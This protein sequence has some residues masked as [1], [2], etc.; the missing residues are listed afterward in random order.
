[1]G[2]VELSSFRQLSCFHEHIRFSGSLITSFNGV[3][4]IQHYIAP[5]GFTVLSVRSDSLST[6]T[7]IGWSITLGARWIQNSLPEIPSLVSVCVTTF[8]KLTF[9]SSMTLPS[10]EANPITLYSKDRRTFIV[11]GSDAVYSSTDC[12]QLPRSFRSLSHLL[13]HAPI[14]CMNPRSPTNKKFSRQADYRTQSPTTSLFALT[15]SALLVFKPNLRSL[16]VQTEVPQP[17]WLASHQPPKSSS[18]FRRI[19]CL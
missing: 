4:P 16:I 7:S 6:G 10:I 15:E 18:D 12:T 1:M 9:A 5:G 13:S 8:Y 14:E 11:Q 17:H 19:H 2:F 3:L